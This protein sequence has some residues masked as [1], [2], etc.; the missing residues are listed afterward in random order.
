MEFKCS[1][2][3]CGDPAEV[4]YR[5]YTLCQGCLSEAY[6]IPGTRTPEEM[7]DGIGDEIE[8][9]RIEAYREAK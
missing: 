5:G 2:A 4:V 8:R 6:E 7:E 3:G 1:I 9:L